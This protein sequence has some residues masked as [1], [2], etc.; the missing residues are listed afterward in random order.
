MEPVSE[1]KEGIEA[2]EEGTEAQRNKGTEG[3]GLQEKEKAPAVRQQIEERGLG[4]LNLG[5]L[6][7]ARRHVLKNFKGGQK[8]TLNGVVFMIRAITHK[9]LIVRPISVLVKAGE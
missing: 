3:E 6:G 4:V 1:V 7:E 8:F 9:D 5:T 2:Q